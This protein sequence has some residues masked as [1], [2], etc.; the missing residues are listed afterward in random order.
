[1]ELFQ[2]AI[3]QGV[4]FVPGPAFH[5]SGGGENTMRLN[6]SNSD[7]TRIEDGIRRLASAL[8]QL[9]TSQVAR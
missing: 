7:P 5:A 8:A 4:A 6:F 3:E 2:L 9:Q 1:L